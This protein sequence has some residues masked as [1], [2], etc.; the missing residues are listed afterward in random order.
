MQGT[1]ATPTRT[2]MHSSYWLPSARFN[3]FLQHLQQQGYEI[4]GPTI[5]DGAI[6]YGLIRN[7]NDLPQGWTDEQA[8][9]QYRLH[10][11]QD[12]FLFGYVVGPHSWKKYLFPSRLRLWEIHKEQTQYRVEVHQEAVAKRAFLGMRGCE[13]HALQV[14]DRVFLDRN[15][16]VVDPHYESVRASTL[17]IGVECTTVGANCFC[18]SMG[19]GP[20][21]RKSVQVTNQPHES[22][23]HKAPRQAL[24]MAQSTSSDV[25][26]W[27]DIVLTEVAD[28][29]IVRIE[30]ELGGQ[31]LQVMNLDPATPDQVNSGRGAVEH[32]ANQISKHL[33]ATH[34]QHVLQRNLEHPRWDDVATRCLGCTNCTMVCPTCFCVS[35]EEVTDLSLQTSARERVWDSCFN[36][37]FAY[38]HG[39]NFR[40]HLSARYRQWLTHKF[41]TWWDQFEISGCVGCGR[42]ITWCP[43]GIDVTEE[44]KAIRMT[45]GATKTAAGG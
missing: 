39:G 14:Q 38:V 45:D 34:V 12:D 43:V 25:T 44:I 13:L 33:D 36:P 42:C 37:D 31:V 24:P 18:T 32:A 9:G 2:A 7:I 4:L 40:P 28:G 41:S 22:K 35:V 23:H 20:A 6:I 1:S 8:P 3:E 5:V 29:F 26:T 16:Q 15:G 10:R 19:T 30:T 27:V 17:L 11:R 21:I